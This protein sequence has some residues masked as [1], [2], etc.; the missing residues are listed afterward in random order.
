MPCQSPAAAVVLSLAG[1]TA[2]K[3]RNETV[4]IFEKGLSTFHHER[5]AA[6]VIVS[7]DRKGQ[8]PST[9]SDRTV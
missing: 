1:V 4:E 6:I 8:L 3:I 7:D 2:M 9:P 5:I